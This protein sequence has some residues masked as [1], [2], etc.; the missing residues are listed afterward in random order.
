MSG[1]TN[2]SKGV[3][4]GHCF[5]ITT[6]A[7]HDDETKWVGWSDVSNEV[8]SEIAGLWESEYGTDWRETV[9]NLWCERYGH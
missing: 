8:T 5:D 2:I 1:T 6:L 3:W 9:C 4:A 7:R